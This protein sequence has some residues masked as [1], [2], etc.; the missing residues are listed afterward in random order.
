MSPLNL[1]LDA[2]VS[3]NSLILIQEAGASRHDN[4]FIFQTHRK[5]SDLHA[6]PSEIAAART[7]SIIVLTPRSVTKCHKFRRKRLTCRPALLFSDDLSARVSPVSIGRSPSFRLLKVC[8]EG[9]GHIGMIDSCIGS[10]R[11][12]IHIAFLDEIVRGPFPF[13]I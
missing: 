3:A 6:F 5:S 11:F 9:G 7:S 10:Y 1:T 12:N 4:L 8:P 13:L 2:I